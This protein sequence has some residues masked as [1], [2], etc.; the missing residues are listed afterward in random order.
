MNRA[1]PTKFNE[2]VHCK[3]IE[4]EEV[5]YKERTLRDLSEA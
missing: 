3:V 1:N 5:L 2:E 4:D